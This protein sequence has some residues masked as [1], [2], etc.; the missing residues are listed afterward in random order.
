MSIYE[1]IWAYWTSK[2]MGLVTW[3]HPAF[4]FFRV[5]RPTPELRDLIFTT[6]PVIPLNATEARRGTKCTQSSTQS[7]YY[8][9]TKTNPYRLY[10]LAINNN[11]SSCSETHNMTTKFANQRGIREGGRILRT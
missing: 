10:S 11:C 9:A 6:R 5:Q 8:F 4:H 1:I 3:T 2:D 7:D